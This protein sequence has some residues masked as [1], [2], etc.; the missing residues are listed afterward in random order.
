MSRVASIIGLKGGKWH[1]ISA[2]LANELSDEYKHGDFKGFLRVY[3]L[4]SSGSTKRKKG[5]PAAA[6]KAKAKKSSE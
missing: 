1:P 2:G 5:K 6:Q 3:Y 4:P